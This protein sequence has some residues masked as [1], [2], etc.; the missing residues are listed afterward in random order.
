MCCFFVVAKA[1]IRYWLFR[2]VHERPP[3][4]RHNET[5]RVIELAAWLAL[6]AVFF[7][8]LNSYSVVRTCLLVA[9]LVVYDVTMRYFFL[10][11]E[12][13]RLL[14]QSRKWSYRSA[15]RQVLRRARMPVAS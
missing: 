1:Y 2:P 7:F 9:G 8:S 3:F 6:I 5:L 15:S 4:A 11:I 14:A 13:R 12:I 10:Q